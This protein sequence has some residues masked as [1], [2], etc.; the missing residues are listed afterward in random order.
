MHK[1]TG[2]SVSMAIGNAGM[3]AVLGAWEISQ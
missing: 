1:E 3:A 2:K